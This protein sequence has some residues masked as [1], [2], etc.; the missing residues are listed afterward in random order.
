[1]IRDH[2]AENG[3]VGGQESSNVPLLWGPYHYCANQHTE[4]NLEY[5]LLDQL[6]LVLVA[7][8]KVHVRDLPAAHGFVLEVGILAL[9][10]SLVLTRMM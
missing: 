4:G 7:R 2:R 9:H 8:A 6:G 3:L 5:E 10:L 1:M